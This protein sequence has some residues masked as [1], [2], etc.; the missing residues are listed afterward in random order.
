MMLDIWLEW[1]K[2]GNIY[3]D[4][5]KEIVNLK[6]QNIKI[7]ESCFKLHFIRLL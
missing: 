1:I 4:L 3:L 5:E 7:G 2:D 6:V